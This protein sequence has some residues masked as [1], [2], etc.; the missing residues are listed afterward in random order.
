VELENQ[1]AKWRIVRQLFNEKDS[2]LLR[3]I[4]LLC[5][6]LIAELR[7]K[8]DEA[9]GDDFLVNQGGI[10]AFKRLVEYA[11]KPLPEEKKA[12]SHEAGSFNL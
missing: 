7:E 3:N 12:M 2:L 11:T 6:I 9:R 8:N 10:Q 4:V 5:E 1:E